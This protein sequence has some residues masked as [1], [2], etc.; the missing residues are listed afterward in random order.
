MK[1]YLTTVLVAAMV[2]ATSVVVPAFGYKPGTPFQVL[3]CN[4]S[5]PRQLYSIED[6][7]SFSE[8]RIGRGKDP[9]PNDVIDSAGGSAGATPH[10]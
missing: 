4:A 5:N 10:V 1:T 7:G 8:I 9:N 6:E 3:P 2:A